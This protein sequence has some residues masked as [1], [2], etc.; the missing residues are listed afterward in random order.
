M[1]ALLP[2]GVTGRMFCNFSMSFF[3]FILNS[4]VNIF[5][6]NAVH[7]EG[8]QSL[9]PTQLR[10]LLVRSIAWYTYLTLKYQ[11]RISNCMKKS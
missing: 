1:L 7:F 5:L 8:K 4:K 11:G 6:C 3:N 9:M 10:L 2:C